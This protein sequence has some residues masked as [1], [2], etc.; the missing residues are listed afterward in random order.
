LSDLL[1]RIA[2]APITWGVDASP[3]WG[4][5]MDRGRVLDEMTDVGLTATE[6]GPD[7]WLPLDPDELAAFLEEH[8]Q[9]VVGGFVPAV[10]YREPGI[11]DQL[12][13]VERASGQLARAGARV[14]VLAADSHS[15][16]YD[17]SMEMSEDEW[18]IFLPNLERVIEIGWKSGLRTTLHP[19][20]G[21]AIERRNHVERLLESSDVDLCLD[22]GHMFLAGADPVEIAR[23]ASSRVH[24]VHLKDVDGVFAEK[25]QSGA[26]RFRQSVIDGMFVPLGQ[27][28][29][30]IEGTIRVLE[31][32]GYRGWYVLEQDV[33][34]ADDPQ[35]GAGPRADAETSLHYLKTLA[36][37]L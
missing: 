25:V 36:T 7:G 4:F 14:M 11:E 23:M 32:G 34:L 12:A 33:S 22:T 30:D 15:P 27:G 3:G 2:G 16:G 18:K 37:G 6:L 21:M 26:A 31:G 24:H 9:R 13:Y 29:V 19:H 8:H 17:E 5:L 35:E 10:L 20:W 28:A 1:E